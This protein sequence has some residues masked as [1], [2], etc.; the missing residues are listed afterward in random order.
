MHTG[1]RNHGSQAPCNGVGLTHEL[2]A[3][4]LA[5]ARLL[6]PSR[7]H[8]PQSS[9][10]STPGRPG[11]TEIAMDPRS[12]HSGQARSNRNRY[13]SPLHRLLFPP[14]RWN[15]PVLGPDPLAASI[16]LNVYLSH[17]SKTQLELPMLSDPRPLRRRTQCVLRASG[18]VHP[19]AGCAP[20]PSAPAPHRAARRSRRVGE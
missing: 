11:Q 15:R 18:P 16:R 7:S 19:P 8:G 4:P 3:A 1:A 14:T 6:H 17:P 2:T 10:E 12:I 13:G 5:P 20:D 9:R